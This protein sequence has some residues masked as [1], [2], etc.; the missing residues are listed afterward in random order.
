MVKDPGQTAYE[1]RPIDSGWRWRD[2]LPPSMEYWASIEAAVRADERERCA[3]ACENY[4][5]IESRPY[6]SYFAAAIRSLEP[7]GG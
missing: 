5:G 2:L 3:K 7:R 6:R 4:I 1:A